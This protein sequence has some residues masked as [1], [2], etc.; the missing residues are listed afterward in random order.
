[1]AEPGRPWAQARS[2]YRASEVLRR[3]TGR[4][5]DPGPQSNGPGQEDARAPGR[6]ARLRGQLRAEAASR[7]E[8]PRLLKL[9]ERAG[10]GAAGRGRE[11]RRAQPRAPC[12]RYAGSPAAGPPTRRGSWR[13]ASGGCR[14]AWRQCA[15]SWAPGL[16]RCARS[17]ERSWMPCARCC[18]RRRPR[19]PAASPA[20]SPAPRPAARPCRGRS[21]PLAPWS[22]PPGPQTTPRTAQQNAER[23]EPRPG[24]TT[25]RCQCRLGPRKVAGTE[26]GRTRAA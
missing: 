4:R 21:A 11:D 19:L 18:R 14:R 12:A 25:R 9:V 10:A 15:R 17:F 24:R 2:A 6:M 5:R 20:P 8:V 23:T 26:G 16:R 7:S 22:P 1:M 13:S 3:G